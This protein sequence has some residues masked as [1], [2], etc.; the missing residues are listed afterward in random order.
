VGAFIWC[1]VTAAAILAMTIMY[2]LTKSELKKAVHI[3]EN[4]Y[5]SPMISTPTVYGIIS[6]KIII[7]AAIAADQF[8]F[9]LAHEK[10]HIRRHD[11]IWR[12]AAILTAC[13]HW[14]NPLIWWFLKSFL[15]D[16]ELAC[17]AAA[18]K[19]MNEEERK[20]YARTLLAFTKQSGTV[21]ASAFGSS[22]VRIRIENVLTYKKLTLFSTLCFI[23]MG[24]II[25][26]LLL[27][28]AS[29]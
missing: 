20:D 17:D 3:T 10:V 23:G 1:I 11:N 24:I 16:M 19:K 27:T 25:T 18:I 28:N 6:P 29:V 13:I 22:R 2:F 4:I 26:F 8:T 14:F 9:V 7:P 21:F 12:M 5:T 15:S